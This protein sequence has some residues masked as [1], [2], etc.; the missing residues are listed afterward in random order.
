MV[1]PISKCALPL[2]HLQVIGL[3]D[4][5][6]SAFRHVGDGERSRVFDGALP[7]QLAR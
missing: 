2:Q 5:G 4:S 3:G 6:P 7:N 1:P